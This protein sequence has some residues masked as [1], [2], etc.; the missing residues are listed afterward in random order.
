MKYLNG[1]DDVIKRKKQPS[2]IELKKQT[3]IVED[4][5]MMSALISCLY[6]R[7]NNFNINT[8]YDK[9]AEI[10]KIIA[11][12]TYNRSKLNLSQHDDKIMYK[13]L[14]DIIDKIDKIIINPG[15]KTNEKDADSNLL[16]LKNSR[17]TLTEHNKLL[18]LG[19]SKIRKDEVDENYNFIVENIKEPG[20]YK[21]IE[22]MIKERPSTINFV[23]DRGKTLIDKAID[24]LTKSFT[25][26]EDYYNKLHYQ[27]LLKLFVKNSL[28]KVDISKLSSKI[29]YLKN[30]ISSSK[31]DSF[32]KAGE[33]ILIDEL[34]EII[35]ERKKN[36]K[37]I[38]G[39]Q[40][41]LR[42][43]YQ[44]QEHCT[45][46]DIRNLKFPKETDYIDYI[47]HTKEHTITID[48]KKTTKFEDAFSLT[49]LNDGY[50]LKIY[51]VD[52]SKYIEYD[53]DVAKYASEKG[54]SYIL[55][56]EF[57]ENNISLTKNKVRPAICHEFQLDK[58]FL[59]INAGIYKT[60]IKV[61]ENYNHSEFNHLLKRGD[62]LAVDYYY[63]SSNLKRVM[64]KQ[65]LMKREM[66]ESSARIA[67]VRNA[68]SVIV[69]D[70]LD[71]AKQDLTNRLDLPLICR[72]T[73]MIEKNLIDK[74]DLHFEDDIELARA[75][76]AITV[77]KKAHNDKTIFSIKKFNN[78]N[79]IADFFAPARKG[80]SLF[81]QKIL[82]MSRDNKE[83]IQKAYLEEI[84]YK[85]N[86]KQSRK[87][88]FN[89]EY[90][91][92]KTRVIDKSH[93]KY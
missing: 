85:L 62:Q 68:S 55:P 18:A 67:A 23:D 64:K 46:K 29:D 74:C 82:V 43:K 15:K 40:E 26:K 84:C 13:D 66:V 28:A 83:T 47:D 11:F 12:I 45:E 63:V 39:A 4:N 53:N 92:V 7:I 57:V 49:K 3:G 75:K 19:N 79:Q 35:K 93:R 89:E 70:I 72:K 16:L 56:I 27:K 60:K 91:R 76:K 90:G 78:D 73:S 77:A 69:N 20:N 14:N 38:K 34:L 5:E 59:V 10:K 52:M 37:I 1:F 58:N 41:K 42:L 87:E 25:D 2:F 48:S 54:Y 51:A 71:F 21:A 81:N 61:A 31:K 32:V 65:S 80:D 6:N 33:N 88:D 17:S 36:D 8:K 30:Y 9:N 22:E 50:L 24:L 86:S 44:L